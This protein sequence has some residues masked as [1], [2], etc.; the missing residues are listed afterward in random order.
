MGFMRSLV[1]GTVWKCRMS[2]DAIFEWWTPYVIKRAAARQELLRV[3]NEDYEA[4]TKQ[5]IVSIWKT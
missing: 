3:A 4:Y 2:N 1:K 5:D